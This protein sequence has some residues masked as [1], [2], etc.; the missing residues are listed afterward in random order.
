MADIRELGE[1]HAPD[2]I[3]K[4]TCGTCYRFG[5]GAVARAVWPCETVR[6]RER[7]AASEARVA[8]LREVFALSAGREVIYAQAL[9]DIWNAKI[10][11]G[12]V[13]SEGDDTGYQSPELYRAWLALNA[14]D[15]LEV[16]LGLAPDFEHQRRLRKERIVGRHNF[17]RYWPRSRHPRH[18]RD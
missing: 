8:A 16:A 17:R 11:D 14:A 15:E 13:E 9:E 4:T 18:G 1:Q 5:G 6:L 10:P 7:I 12:Y 2:L 3:D